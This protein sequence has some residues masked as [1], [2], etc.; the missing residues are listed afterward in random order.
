MENVFFE[1]RPRT[2][3]TLRPIYRRALV[4]GYVSD[5]DKLGDSGFNLSALKLHMRNAP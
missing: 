1:A 4:L 3:N 5:P 2:I